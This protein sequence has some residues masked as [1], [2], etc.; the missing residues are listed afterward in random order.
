MCPAG[1]PGEADRLAPGRAFG[2]HILE[3]VGSP[4]AIEQ[5]PADGKVEREP[6]QTIPVRQTATGIDYVI[7]KRHVPPY[8]R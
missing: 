4:D 7:E 6:A 1:D 5:R 8:Q 2:C 3:S